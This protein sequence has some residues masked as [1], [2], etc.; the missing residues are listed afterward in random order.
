MIRV[1]LNGQPKAIDDCLTV[2]R[3]VSLLQLKSSN[4][5]IAVN[6]DVVPRSEFPQKKIKDGDKIEIIR[7][8]AGG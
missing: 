4:I 3:L 5:A 7:P 8:V 6:F 1:Q 2:E